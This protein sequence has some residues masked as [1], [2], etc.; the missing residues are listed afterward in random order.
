[1]KILKME[2]KEKE[3]I[4][5]AHYKNKYETHTKERIFLLEPENS[6]RKIFLIVY[7]T[8]E[9]DWKGSQKEAE[10]IIYSARLVK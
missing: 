2:K 3:A 9:R 5:E 1:M 6:H 4:F 8:L 10:R 7:M